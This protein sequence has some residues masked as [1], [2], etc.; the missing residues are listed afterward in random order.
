[1]ESNA[2]ALLGDEWCRMRIEGSPRVELCLA[3][4]VAVEEP[5]EETL[6]MKRGISRGSRKGEAEEGLT[7]RPSP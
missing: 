7:S 1:M 2:L 5:S 6:S 3:D 4:G